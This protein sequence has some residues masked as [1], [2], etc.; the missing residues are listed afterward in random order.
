MAKRP[1]RDRVHMPR[2]AYLKDRDAAL[3]EGPDE[4][5]A[6][7]IGHRSFRGTPSPSP[8]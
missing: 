1:A 2:V 5:P 8:V 6:R 7:E 3:A 4:P